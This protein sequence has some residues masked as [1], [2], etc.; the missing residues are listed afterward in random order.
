MKEKDLNHYKD[1]LLKNI[2]N[3]RVSYIDVPD[4]FNF[5]DYLIYLGSRELIKNSDCL[6]CE[7]YTSSQISSN[8]NLISK[9]NTD[10]II[11]HGG[12]N[13]GDLY[14]RHNNIRLELVK[15]FPDIPII[16]FPQTI[17]YQDTANM[18]DD[19]SVL[20]THSNLSIFV[21][22]FES[23]S[24][25]ENHSSLKADIC[26]D[27]AQFLFNTVTFTKARNNKNLRFKKLLFKRIDKERVSNE[28]TA[29]SKDW[30]YFFSPFDVFFKRT[31]NFL[32]IKLS[33]SKRLS[34]MMVMLWNFYMDIK[35]KVILDFFTSYE[36]IE[37]DRLHGYIL[38]YLLDM[39]RTALDNSY[40]KIARYI[41]IFKV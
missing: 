32:S 31:F 34:N 13:F 33:F 1:L 16:L 38:A 14:E 22:D 37:T 11:C 39:K 24:I 20:E 35:L 29:D 40:G 5:G 15:K 19:L 3:K 10:V 21:R 6:S 36:E 23:K 17:F 9:D 8:F 27:T 28:T 2:S 25:I 4:H 18:L 26:C 41:N 7:F 12:G 30:D